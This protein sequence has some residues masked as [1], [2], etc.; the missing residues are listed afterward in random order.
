MK[1]TLLYIVLILNLVLNSCTEDF[2]AIDETFIKKPVFNCILNCGDSVQVAKLYWNLP[3]NEDGT[4]SDL[5]GEIIKDALIRIWWDE[6]VAF[7][8]YAE[9]FTDDSV[10]FTDVY[11][12]SDFT[13]VANKNYEVEIILKTGQRFKA[14]TLSPDEI[15]F[16]AFDQKIPMVDDFGRP[17]DEISLSWTTGFR[18]YY[19]SSRFLIFYKDAKVGDQILR[20]VVPH[21]YEI[22][23]GETIKYFPEPSYNSFINV[24]QNTFDLAL[25]EISEN[26]PVKSNF[27]IYSF[28]LE[29]IIFDSH[30]SSYFASVNSFKE[31][32]SIILN[33]RT[34]SNIENGLG[35][36]GSFTKQRF[37]LKFEPPYIESFG[38]EYA[39]SLEVQGW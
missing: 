3:P 16:M 26:D 4:A 24:K 29:T 31:D 34:Y 25:A 13:P 21:S 7:M 27:S 28:M 1:K 8:H 20:K 17:L 30:F 14:A 11:Y 9:E 15:E 32:Y 10:T 36:F 37:A 2:V 12:N 18:D 39:L 6:E 5:S 35:I 23:D 38:Y 19:V 33:Q 22:I